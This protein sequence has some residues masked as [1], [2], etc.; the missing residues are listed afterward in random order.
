MTDDSPHRTLVL[1]LGNPIRGDDGVGW[2]VVEVLQA[3]LAKTFWKP[4]QG[5]E[6]DTVAGG[7]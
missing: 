2:R 7:G 5:F 1:G 3:N 4:S 6:F